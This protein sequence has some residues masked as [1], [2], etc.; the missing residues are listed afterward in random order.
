MGAPQPMTID[1]NVRAL[2]V[3]DDSEIRMLISSFLEKHGILSHTAD[4]VAAMRSRLAANRYDVVVLDVMMPGESGLDALQQL[5]GPQDPPV[6]VVSALGD[7]IDRIVGLEMGA[8]D[9]LSKPCNPR[10]L[11]ARIRAILR[12]GARPDAASGPDGAASKLW[13]DCL[14]FADWRLDLRLRVL[15]DPDGVIVHLSSGEFRLLLAFAERSKHVLSRDQLLDLS[16]GDDSVLYDR[17]I[18]V[19]VSRLRRKLRDAGGDGDVIRTIRNEGYMFVPDVVKGRK[20]R[21][22]LA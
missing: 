15:Y 17:A 6:I 20:Q 4:T 3:D 11:L 12:R 13:D 14:M 1:P 7:E 2:V 8:Q 22:P 18:D 10:E 16:R 5:Q 9:Y 19:Q 21:T